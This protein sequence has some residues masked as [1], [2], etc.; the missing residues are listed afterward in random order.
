MWR[1][2]GKSEELATGVHFFHAWANVTAIRTEAGLVRACTDLRAGHFGDL[3]L[4]GRA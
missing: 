1:P 3:G 4:L 2:T